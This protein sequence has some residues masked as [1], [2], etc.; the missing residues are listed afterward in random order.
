[1]PKTSELI[2]IKCGWYRGRASTLKV[3]GIIS[4]VPMHEA[5]IKVYQ[6][7]EKWQVQKNCHMA[8]DIDLTYNLY[9]KLLFQFS[10]YLTFGKDEYGV[11]QKS[12]LTDF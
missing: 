4:Y 1:M 5:Q 3:G 2:S 7:Y 6:F 8:Q 12:L 9:F 11:I 10:E